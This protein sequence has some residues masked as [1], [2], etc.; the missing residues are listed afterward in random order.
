MI[1]QQ[2]LVGALAL[3]TPDAPVSGASVPT[4]AFPT[5]SEA[6]AALSPDL[7][8]AGGAALGQAIAVLLLSRRL[9]FTNGSAAVLDHF[10]TERLD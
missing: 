3:L 4:S 1:L 5:A 10:S 7:G 9:N 6:A 8:A 2:N